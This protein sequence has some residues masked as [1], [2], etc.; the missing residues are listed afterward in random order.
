MSDDTFTPSLLEKET[1]IAKWWF[2]ARWSASVFCDSIEER[3]G[4]ID[5]W[6]NEFEDTVTILEEAEIL[7]KQASTKQGRSNKK[8]GRKPV[9][10]G[11]EIP[12][13]F[14]QCNR[15]VRPSFHQKKDKNNTMDDD[16]YRI[17]DQSSTYDSGH[18]GSYDTTSYD[19][20]SFYGKLSGSKSRSSFSSGRNDSSRRATRGISIS[21]LERESPSFGSKGVPLRQHSRSFGSQSVSS[22]E[23]SHGS[24]VAKSSFVTPRKMLSTYQSPSKPAPTKPTQTRGARMKAIQKSGSC[25]KKIA[26]GKQR[27]RSTKESVNPR[28]KSIPY[29][30]KKIALGKQ[31]ARSTKESV[32]PRP[33]S[34]P[35]TVNHSVF[36]EKRA[37]GHHGVQE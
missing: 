37:L 2:A 5:P 13:Q 30:S 17:V 8:K 35:Y 9:K 7:D 11:K 21:N 15:T 12:S 28:P 23:R 27:A 36:H 24:T 18:D 32:N 16:S 10:N 25:N 4:C 20:D 26:L 1:T 33:K 29:N 34:I 14:V 3:L 22:A 19:E 6:E 31:R